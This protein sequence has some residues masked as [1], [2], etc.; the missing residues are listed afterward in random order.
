MIQDSFSDEDVPGF[1]KKRAKCMR[2][3]RELREEKSV[4]RG[5]GPVCLARLKEE[6]EIKRLQEEEKDG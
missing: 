1:G 5:L 4:R 3:G 2:C 6:D